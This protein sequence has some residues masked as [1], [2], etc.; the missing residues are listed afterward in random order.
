MAES[1]DPYLGNAVCA[2]E[3]VDSTR[4]RNGIT[5]SAPYTAGALGEKI[6]ALSDSGWE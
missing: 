2:A 6:L 1:K 4:R 3:G 5:W